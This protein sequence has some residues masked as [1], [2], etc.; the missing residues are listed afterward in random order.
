MDMN[1]T[2]I[3]F[4]SRQEALVSNIAEETNPSSAVHQLNKRHPN[5]LDACKDV[6][7]GESSRRVS[8]KLKVTGAFRHTEYAKGFY[9]VGD[10]T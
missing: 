7:G 8:P 9:K 6:S 1:K 5:R 2:M 3:N 10:W 4:T